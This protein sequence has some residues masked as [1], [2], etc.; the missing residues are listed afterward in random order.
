MTTVVELPESLRLELKEPLGPI[1]TD[2]TELLAATG[3]PLVTVG[4][5]VTYHVLEA[6]RTP[7]VALVDERTERSAVDPEIAERLAGNDFDV[8]RQV[9]NP[10][11]TLSEPLLR[12]LREAI[13]SGE[14]TLIEVDGEED[15]AALPAIALVPVNASVVYGQPGEGMVNTVVDAEARAQM[16]E[17]LSRMDG[18]TDRLWSLLGVDSP[19]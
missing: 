6:G 9:S 8:V 5:V 16:E 19:T 4:D 15:L 10:A 17:L 3:S 11:A 12:V 14:T 7:T 13:E 1:F 18:D 2:A